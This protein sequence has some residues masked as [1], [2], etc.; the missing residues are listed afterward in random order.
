ME[1]LGRA[2]VPAPETL[3]PKSYRNYTAPA[4]VDGR[5]LVREHDNLW[6]YDVRRHP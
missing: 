5:L 3:P 2:V 6:C 1:I 4:L